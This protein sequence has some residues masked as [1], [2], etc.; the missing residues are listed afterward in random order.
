MIDFIIAIIAILLYIAIAVYMLNAKREHP[1]DPR[2]VDS[3]WWY[4]PM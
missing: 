3:Y 4:L 1:I 2:I